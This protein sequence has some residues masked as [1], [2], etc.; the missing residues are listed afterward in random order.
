[1]L[2]GQLIF[3]A[4]SILRFRSDYDETT[5]L[6]L[7]SI[8]KTIFA[9]DPF[10]LLKFFRHTAQTDIEEKHRSVSSQ[11]KKSRSLLLA[12]QECEA[13]S[14]I[15]F[16]GFPQELVEIAAQIKRAED[17][18]RGTKRYQP[19]INQI[20][21]EYP[22]LREEYPENIAQVRQQVEQ[23]EKTWQTSAMQVR[24]VKELDR[25]RAHLNPEYVNAQK[26]L[27]DKAQAQILLSGDQKRL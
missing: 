11:W 7:I 27:E 14:K 24:L 19:L 8:P 4:D 13:D 26:I 3:C 6:P 5:A 21:K 16:R 18:G 1:M 12:L 20:E 2:E 15:L 9:T 23:S 22:L 17:A 25:V 10:F